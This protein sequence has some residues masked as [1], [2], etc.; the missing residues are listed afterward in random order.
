MSEQYTPPPIYPPSSPPGSSEPPIAKSTAPSSKVSLRSSQF[1]E[2]REKNWMELEFLIDRTEKGGIRSLAASELERLSVLYRS[3]LSSLSVAR[4]IA[5]DRNL[6]VYLENL[7]LRAFLVVYGPRSSMTES[8]SHFLTRGF[9]EAV[10]SAGRH[11]FL[12]FSALMVGV[13]AGFFLVLQNPDWYSTFVS[14]AMAGGRGPGSTREELEAVL[15]PNPGDYAKNGGLIGS[16][17][18]FATALFSNNTMVGVLAFSLGIAAGAPTIVLIAYQGVTLGAFIAIHY[19]QNLTV[20]LLGWLSIHGVTEILAIILCGAAGL[21][22]AEKILFP[23]RY[24]R[25]ENLSIHGH[26]AA[27]VA[28]GA[29]I[30]FF[31]AAILEGF[32]RQLISDTAIRYFIGGATGL[33]WLLYFLRPKAEVKSV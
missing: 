11:I 28:I 33:F 9:P 27:Q 17:A 30:L 3:A 19:K 15:F 20:E 14:E 25:I 23:G 5:L 16:L 26:T 31:V 10:R 13:F 2:E 7:S 4:S 29:M 6:L 24:S 22:V 18:M 8:L 12:A 21:M 32:F 1:R